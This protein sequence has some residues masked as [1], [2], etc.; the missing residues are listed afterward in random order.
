MPASNRCLQAI[1]C[2]NCAIAFS[3][4]SPPAP[5]LAWADYFGRRSYGAIRGVALSVQVSAQ[6]C[7]PMISAVLRDWTGDYVASLEVFAGLSVAAALVIWMARPPGN[8]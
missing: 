1:S 4:S 7:G 5:P 2:P 8:V 6:A 3:N